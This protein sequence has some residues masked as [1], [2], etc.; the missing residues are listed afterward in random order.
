VDS[1]TVAWPDGRT[2]TVR[3]PAA[4]AR[5]AVRQADAAPA[6]APLG[7]PAAAP[8][9]GLLAAVADTAV[10][11]WAHRENDFVDFDRDRLIPKLVSTEGPMAAV[12]DVNGD[13]LDD[14]YLGG[15]KEQPGRLMVQRPDGRFEPSNP[16]LFEPDAISEDLGALFFDANGDG[17]PRPVRGERGQRVPRR[18]LGAAGPA[19][20]QR[21]GRALP[22]GG[23]RA[24]PASS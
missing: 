20:P 9:A 24:A 3:R 12:A 7:T 10:L 17:R 6:A 8:V 2:S 1:V 4:D 14:L 11:P 16:G 5:L 15:A 22:Q 18:H 23:R 13:G 21:G 19:L